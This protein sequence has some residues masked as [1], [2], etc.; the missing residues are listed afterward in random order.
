MLRKISAILLAWAGVFAC[1]GSSDRISDSRGPSY[2]V[3]WRLEKTLGEVPSARGAARWVPVGET[4]VSF[5][6]FRE[7][8]DKD[9]MA[10]DHV[11]FND[12]H[13]LELATGRW[14]KRGPSPNASDWPAPRAFI[15]GAPYRAKNTAIFFGG[16]DYNAHLTS[17]KPYGDMWE[18]DPTTN[19]LT[20]R[21][22]AN[23]GPGPRLGGEIAIAGHTLYLF[24]GID[25]E[26][27]NHN[28]LWAYDLRTDTWRELK[29]DGDPASPRYRYI[30]RFELDEA[31]SN[32]YIFGGNFRDEYSDY[33]SLQRNDT[34]RYNIPN[35]EFSVLLSEGTTNISGRVH[36]VAAVYGGTFVIGLGDI[37]FGGCLVNQA[38]EQQNPT[39]EVWK[40]RI[41]PDEGELVYE[42]VP[43]G[44][45]PPPLKRPLHAR[46][47]D[48]LYVSHG[49]GYRC[50][51]PSSEGPLYNLDTYSLPLSQLR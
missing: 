13:T 43:I 16:A 45:S 34:W 7:C 14:A 23:E 48:R 18:Y 37:H 12:V 24:G 8:F 1:A 42:R 10:C 26:Y 30:F 38:S 47:R 4:L 39:D 35:D 27:L 25:D 2:G 21:K 49:F 6:G 9:T 15:G 11:Y 5:G 44:F 46:V 40:L 3:D 36:G 50:D 31:E 33:R 19:R 22:Y 51:D 17:F 20:Q 28:C 29:Q 32:I 41:G